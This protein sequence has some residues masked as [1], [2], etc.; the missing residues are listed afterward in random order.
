MWGRTEGGQPGRWF[1]SPASPSRRPISFAPGHTLDHSAQPPWLIGVSSDQRNVVGI[2]HAASGTGLRPP[3]CCST[4]PSPDSPKQGLRQRLRLSAPG[5]GLTHFPSQGKGSK[6]FKLCGPTDKIEDFMYF[7]SYLKH[8]HLSRCKPFLLVNCAETGSRLVWPTGHGPLL[9][10][11][12]GH[13]DRGQGEPES[14]S[15]CGTDF[16]LGPLRT[17]LYKDE[18]ETSVT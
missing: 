10:A 9:P 8:S 4:S 2:T 12:G 11:Q 16:L 18:K 14:L 5:K 3:T 13:G 7:H 17:A 15:D 1:G 6:Y